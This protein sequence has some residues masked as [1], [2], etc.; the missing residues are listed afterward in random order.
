MNMWSGYTLAAPCV[1]DIIVSPQTPL[2]FFS[3]EPNCLQSPRVRPS[4]SNLHFNSKQC[5]S[6][7]SRRK[8]RLNFC[9]AANFK[10]PQKLRQG[11]V[12]GFRRLF[13]KLWNS[14]F[15]ARICAPSQPSWTIWLTKGFHSLFKDWVYRI[16]CTFSN[17]EL[18]RQRSHRQ[19][20]ET[21]MHPHLS[22]FPLSC[23][24]NGLSHHIWVMLFGCFLKWWYPKSPILIGFSIINHPF[25]DTTI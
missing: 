11:F 17:M 21:I 6:R 23:I 16:M 20:T 7:V 18:F 24:R 8:H 5:P 2:G 3:A 14:S 22:I 4:I 19:Q 9:C 15:F 12:S 1:Q 10:S 25:W 13:V